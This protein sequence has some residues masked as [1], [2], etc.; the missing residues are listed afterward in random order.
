MRIAV[1]GSGIAGLTCAR[2]LAEKHAVTVFEADGRI[3]G[4]SQTVAIDVGG[5]W[6]D[7]DIGFIVYND[8]NY[9][10]FSQM[11]EDLHVE[12]Q[13]TSMSFSVRCDRTGVEYSGTSIGSL[14][15][16]RRNALRPSFLRMLL[17]IARFNRTGSLDL[18]RLSPE[19]T[20]AEY[21]SEGRYSRAFGEQYLLP[22]G[23]AIWSCPRASFAEFPIRFIL[24][25]FHQHGLLSL[26]DRPVWRTVVGG[27]Q[28]YVAKLVEPFSDR[29]RLSCPV[30]SVRRLEQ[31]VQIAHAEGVDY[32]DEVVFAC[33]SDQALRMLDD[34]DQLETE[35]LSAFPYG[36]NRAVLHTD[37]SVLPRRRR[38]WASWNYHIG[39]DIETQPTVTYNMNLLQRISSS[40]TIC[41][42]LN[43]NQSIDPASILGEYHYSHPLFTTSRAAIQS[44]HDEVLRR[45]RTSFC[46]AYWRNGFHEDGVVSGLAVCRK[47]GIPGWT[48]QTTTSVRLMAATPGGSDS[49]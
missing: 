25:F 31:E 39:R 6:S 41:L 11:L 29:I 47:F 36:D 4:H 44:R 13:P 15:A 21:L 20:V 40:K 37:E 45:R 24:E 38:A 5:H 35:L 48:S 10:N 42:T 32:F 17:D 16:Q 28:R 7:V 19:K 23:A 18:D 14:F 46:G 30:R 43:P 49:Q 12:T 22:M 8:R 33:H 3:G 1:I 26:A 2:L 9:P 34:A 27:S